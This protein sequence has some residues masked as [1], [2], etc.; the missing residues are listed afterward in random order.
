M[1][2]YRSNNELE[3]EKRLKSKCGDKPQRSLASIEQR[4]AQIR[5]VDYFF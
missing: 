2:F 5:K 4:N 1:P 3:M